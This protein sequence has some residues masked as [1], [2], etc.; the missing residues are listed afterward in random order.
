VVDAVHDHDSVV[1]VD[2]VDHAVRAAPGRSQTLQLTLERPTDPMGVIE[3]RPEHELDDRGRGALWE[4]SGLAVSWT[5]DAELE[6]FGL[7]HRVR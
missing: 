5:G 2:L 3:E 7:D 1:L 6:R 4:A